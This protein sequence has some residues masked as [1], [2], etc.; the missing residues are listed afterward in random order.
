MSAN[1]INQCT[2]LRVKV[3]AGSPIAMNTIMVTQYHV[4]PPC[5]LLALAV[6]MRPEITPEQTY[7]GSIPWVLGFHGIRESLRRINASFIGIVLGFVL[8]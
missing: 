7:F 4:L 5:R 6:A 3:S 2:S 8:S 1:H